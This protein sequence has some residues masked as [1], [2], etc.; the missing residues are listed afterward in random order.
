M[1]RAVCL[2]GH[3][4]GLKLSQLLLPRG[5][6][7]SKHLW[8][9]GLWT[10][11]GALMFGTVTSHWPQTLPCKVC[12]NAPYTSGKS[13]SGNWANRIPGLALARARHLGSTP[14]TAS[15]GR[16]HESVSLPSRASLGRCGQLDRHR[17]WRARPGKALQRCKVCAPAPSPGTRPQ[18]MCS[19]RRC[20][21]RLDLHRLRERWQYPSCTASMPA[22]FMT[23][24]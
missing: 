13:R 7:R 2:A 22:P 5:R 23:K 9:S 1:R 19:M 24:S 10:K 12:N 8:M 20:S 16:A 14:L 6:E 18:G 21:R 3:E 4:R 15:W 11:V 17:S